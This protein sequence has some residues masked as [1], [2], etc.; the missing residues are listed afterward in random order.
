MQSKAFSLQRANILQYVFSSTL[1]R[2]EKHREWIG[3]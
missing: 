1:L 2:P 3:D